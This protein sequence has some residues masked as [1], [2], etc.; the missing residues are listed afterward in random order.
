MASVTAILF[1]QPWLLALYNL[2]L[3]LFVDE[4]KKLFYIITNSK[5]V[6][7][8]F[9]YIFRIEVGG[10]YLLV[11]DEQGRNNY[12]PVGGVYKYYPDDIDIGYYFDGEYDG[13]FNSTQDTEDDL[14]LKIRKRKLKNFKKWFS[15]EKSRENSENL[16]REFKEELIDR[17]IVDKDVFS[18]IKYKYVG[19]YTQ[20]S[21]NK[22]LR[23]RQIR[24]YDIFN[25]KLSNSQRTFLK[26]L[27]AQNSEFYVF[28]TQENINNGFMQFSGKRYDIAE[29][30]KL[31]M[32]I[33]SNQLVK[34]YETKEYIAKINCKETIKL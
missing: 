5:Q 16:S 1:K 17:N 15:T 4:I 34:E 31:I 7:V 23:M 6:R 9:S 24:H 21:F 28:A 30:S 12:H 19:S 27:M 13:L 32:N 11:K 8:S 25:I 29:Y 20:K 3:A 22:D 14:R 10:N 2:I 33:K 26:S 18:E